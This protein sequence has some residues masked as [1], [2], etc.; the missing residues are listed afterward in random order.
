MNYTLGHF[1]KQCMYGSNIYHFS[2]R[3]VHLVK[4][5]YEKHMNEKARIHSPYLNRC[6]SIRSNTIIQNNL[7]F[8]AE[9]A[10]YKQNE[11]SV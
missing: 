4:S 3:F 5:F 7:N 2:I 1:S 6:A 8:P 11:F 9:S 10:G